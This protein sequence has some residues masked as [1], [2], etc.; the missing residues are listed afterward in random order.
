MESY[1]LGFDPVSL[2][3]RFDLIAAQRRLDEL[4]DERSV[5]ALAEK[6]GLLRVTGRLDEAH[7]TAKEALLEARLSGDR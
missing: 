5:D 3:E 1:F 2:T 6:I 7:D 4:A